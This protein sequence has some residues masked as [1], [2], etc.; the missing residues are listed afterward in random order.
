MAGSCARAYC[1]WDVANRFDDKDTRRLA[2][3]RAR[4]ETVAPPRDPEVDDEVTPMPVLMPPPP[5]GQSLPTPPAG[6]RYFVTPADY[7]DAERKRTESAVRREVDV[8]VRPLEKQLDTLSA[9]FAEW[10]RWTRN[11]ETARANQIG[12]V[13]QETVLLRNTLDGVKVQLGGIVASEA[14][15]AEAEIAEVK[16][17]RKTRADWLRD[18]AKVGVAVVITA[19]VTKYIVPLL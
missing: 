17:A 12:E 6:V 13:H 8:R 11:T 18:L 15:R 9:E 7:A 4:N 2:V 16:V 5:H 10:A 14:R 3:A 19:V 1:D